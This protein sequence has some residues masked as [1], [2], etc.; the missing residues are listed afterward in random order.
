MARIVLVGGIDELVGAERCAA[1]LTLV[2]VSTG[3]MAA[4]AFAHDVAVSEKFARHLVAVLFL[5]DFL[6]FA[7]IVEVAEEI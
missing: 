1:L 2:A 6:Q 7:L 4:G 5:G 3:S